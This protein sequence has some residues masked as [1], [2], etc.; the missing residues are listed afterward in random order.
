MLTVT[1]QEL[2]VG[3]AVVSFVLVNVVNEFAR[4]EFSSD[5]MLH[6]KPMN[7]IARSV[8]ERREE[9]SVAHTEACSRRRRGINALSLEHVAH[10]SPGAPYR[11]ADLRERFSRVPAI[12]EGHSLLIGHDVH[13]SFLR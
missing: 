10:G 1:A 12:N 4:I 5:P 9:I 8:R 2:K 7:E 3:V 13:G 6:R 11:S